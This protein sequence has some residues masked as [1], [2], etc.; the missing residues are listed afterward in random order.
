[1]FIERPRNEK[2]ISPPPLF[3]FAHIILTFCSKWII[4]VGEKTAVILK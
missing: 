3:F 1:M 2:K 4:I